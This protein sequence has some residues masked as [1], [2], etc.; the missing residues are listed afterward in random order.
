[1]VIASIRLRLLQRLR[2][3]RT[4]VF[5]LLARAAAKLYATLIDS[6]PVCLCVGN[7]DAGV[8]VQ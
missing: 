1:M 4:V 5:V 2:R 8:R 7:F 6:R 3:K